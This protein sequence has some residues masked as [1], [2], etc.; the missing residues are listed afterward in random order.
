MI[1][2]ARQSDEEKMELQRTVRHA[3]QL[4]RVVISG[5]C[6]DYGFDS[7]VEVLLEE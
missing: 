5:H 3:L 2:T 4:F 6:M 7:E 1:D